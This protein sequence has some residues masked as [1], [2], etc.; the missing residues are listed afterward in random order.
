MSSADTFL[1]D[2][3]DNPDDDA[4]RLVFAD[5][6]EDHG[7]PE[8]AEFIRLQVRLAQMPEHDPA[9]FELE[10]RAQ[11][12]LAEHQARWLGHLPK[13]ARAVELSFRRGLPEEV[14]L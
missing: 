7:D 5:W 12:L 1:A 14:K 2:I 9:R 3:R 4:V 6:L 8:R 11:D 13:W 10:E